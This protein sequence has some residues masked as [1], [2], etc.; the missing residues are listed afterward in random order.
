LPIEGRIDLHGMD[1][2]TAHL[3][4][5]AFVNHHWLRGARC[6]LIITGKGSR[7]EGILRRAVPRWLTDPPLSQQVLSFGEARPGDG[8]AGA[9]YILLRRHRDGARGA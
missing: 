7:G 2:H 8:G 9:L 6:V 1:Q 4:L 3:A 5:R